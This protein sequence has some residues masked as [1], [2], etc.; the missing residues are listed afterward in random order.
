MQ[1]E[2]VVI[3]ANNG[4]KTEKLITTSARKGRVLL[5]EP[6]PFL[7]AQLTKKFEGVDSIAIMN[8][9]VTPSDGVVDC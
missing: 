4:T 2:L 5:I 3:G 1:F 7:Y 9:C 8:R 6:V